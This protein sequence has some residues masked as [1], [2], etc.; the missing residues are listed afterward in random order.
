MRF[1]D[2]LILMCPY[3]KSLREYDLTG[4]MSK[5][6]RGLLWILVQICE[7]IRV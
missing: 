5:P 4:W 3:S 6:L 1:G 2:V 7:R